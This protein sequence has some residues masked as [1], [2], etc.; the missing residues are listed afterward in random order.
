MYVTRWPQLY[1]NVVCK[2]WDKKAEENS[3][4]HTTSIRR[5][6]QN[7]AATKNRAIPGLS[8]YLT[9]NID[10]KTDLDFPVFRRETQRHTY[11]CKDTCS[12]G[13]DSPRAFR[14]KQFGGCTERHRHL[15]RQNIPFSCFS[16]KC[17]VRICFSDIA[18]II[19]VPRSSLTTSWE[20]WERM[21]SE[22]YMCGLC[23]VFGWFCCCF[24]LFSL[25]AWGFFFF[26]KKP[27]HSSLLTGCKFC[28]FLRMFLVFESPVSKANTFVYDSKL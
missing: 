7:K 25:T 10:T 16:S 20:Q 26:T 9:K 21:L 27:H 2:S 12:V 13:C 3:A 1:K 11:P 17:I 22:L 5:P 6:K 4:N 18:G 15:W 23:L 14:C 19:L 24:C 8:T 28:Y